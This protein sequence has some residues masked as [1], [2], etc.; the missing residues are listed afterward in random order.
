MD[1]AI[2]DDEIADISEIKLPEGI[3]VLDAYK[4]VRKFN[5]ITWIEIVGSM[6]YETPINNALIENLKQCYSRQNIIV[7]KRTKRGNKD[8]D[9][10]PYIKNVSFCASDN[11]TISAKISA[12]NPTLKTDDLMNALDEKS[13]PEY[14]SIKRIEIY[15]TNMIKFR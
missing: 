8:L 15:D 1:V 5:E 10:A 9:I 3:E 7:S 6:H 14:M 13:K 11:I 2:M 4:P 12:Q